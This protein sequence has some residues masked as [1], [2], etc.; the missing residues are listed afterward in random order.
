[1]VGEEGRRRTVDVDVRSEDRAAGVARYEPAV[2]GR[3]AVGVQ[4]DPG[5]E[6]DQPRV[7]GGAVPVRER[8]R[9]AG[10]ET[11]ERG[12]PEPERPA[13]RPVARPPPAGHGRAAE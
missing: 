13:V 4:E 1:A 11:R 12:P 5:A 10:S 9:V 2:C 3:R 8:P 7:D 6:G